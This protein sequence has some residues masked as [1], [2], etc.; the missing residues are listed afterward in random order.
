MF[1]PILFLSCMF[2]FKLLETISRKILS[3]N[4]HIIIACMV[5]FV[6]STTVMI[7]VVYDSFFEVLDD[8]NY[9][10]INDD[11]YKYLMTYTASYFMH[12][13]CH[14]LA[15][16][17]FRFDDSVH[18]ILAIFGYMTGMNY[19]KGMYIAYLVLWTEAST[20]FLAI[21]LILNRLKKLGI[22]DNDSLVKSN[23]IC[24]ALMFFLCRIVFI[25]RW[26]FI[27]YSHTIALTHYIIY[28]NVI[29]IY[30]LNLYWFKIII[31]KVISSVK[32]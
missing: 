16:Q 9:Y 7:P 6:H 4:D 30:L 15:H 24:F 1:Y 3:F 23:S 8:K 28:G 26:L 21:H 25:G 10:E 2:W 5:S 14:S 27:L 22:Y 32:N 13:V 11:F 20:P 29:M 31:G 19:N 17:S 18:H 12:D